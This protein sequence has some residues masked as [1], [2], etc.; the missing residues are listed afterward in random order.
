MFRIICESLETK[1]PWQALLVLH[2]LHYTVNIST[3]F[4]LVCLLQKQQMFA[5]VL[6]FRVVTDAGLSIKLLSVV[7]FAWA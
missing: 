7:F 1:K 3:M 5:F 2:T 6:L 4:A